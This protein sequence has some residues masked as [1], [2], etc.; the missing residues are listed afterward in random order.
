MDDNWHLK[1][2]EETFITLKSG[3]KGLTHIDAKKRLREFGPNRLETSKGPSAWVIFFRQF[4]NPLILILIVASAVKLFVSGFLDG[5][6]LITTIL[7][8]AFI[9]FFQE[10]KAEKA[11]R[12]LKK[13]AAHKSKVIRNS[14]VE[15]VLTENL[16]PGDLILLEMGDK[17]PADA[18]LIEVK[19]LKIDESMLDGESIPSEKHSR[20]LEGTPVVAD[21]ENMVYAGTVVSYGKAS[22]VVVA[23]GMKTEL[24][25]IAASIDEIHPE[26]TPVQRSIQSIGNWMLVIVFIAIALFA[27]ISFYKGMP[28]IDIFLLGVAAAVS[29]I[30]E[31]LPIAFTTTLAAGMN[32]MA[33]RNAI[34]RKLIAVETLGSTTAICSDKTGTLTL[35]QMTVTTLYTFERTVEV[36]QHCECLPLFKQMFEIGALCNDAHL[37]KEGGEFKTIGDPT[38]GALLSVAAKAGF[39]FNSPRLNEIPFLSETRYMATLHETELGKRI[40]VKGAPEKVLSLCGLIQTQNGT[41]PLEGAAKEQIQQAIDQMTEKALRLIAVAYLDSSDLI[42]EAFTGKLIFAGIFG[43]IDPPRKEAMEAIHSCRQAGIRVSMITGDNK[44]TALAIAKE[45]GISTRHALTGEELSALSD[46]ELKERSKTT[47]V[48][49]R[50]EPAHKLRIVRAFQSNGQIVAVTGDGIN[51]APALEA[52]N[53][54]IAMG[55]TGTDVAKESADMILADDRFDSIVAAVEEGRAIFNRL[56]NVCAFLL[57]TCIGELFGLILAVFFIG[58]APLL[59][60]QILWVNLVSGSVIAIPLGFEPKIG[61]EMKHPPRDPHSMLLYPG[62][63]YRIGFLAILLGAGT[64]SIFYYTYHHTSLEKAR[65][66]V[67]CALVAFEWLIALK[68]RSEELPI[69]KIGI[70]KNPSLLLAI[71]VALLL[72]LLILYIPALQVLFHTQP[73]SLSEWGIALLPGISI[74]ILETLRKEFLPNLFSAGKWRSVK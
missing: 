24:G 57:T 55:L 3:L 5:A 68:M 54:G 63:L 66:M 45:L 37:S 21:R 15:M 61:D 2:V 67:L 72:H 70:F 19:T 43:M 33:K 32:E 30:P 74:F 6:V 48:Y 50:V 39:Q 9:G 17:V 42:E 25:K 35:N 1:T 69:R 29:A 4:M 47:S 7:L 40:Y 58:L 53:I 59:P 46:P 26:P 12:A 44:K 27:L 41:I 56:R 34:I 51:D 62:M 11:M 28:W 71:G 60:L 20:A 52:S 23:T 18:R 22:A 16:V 8:M 13:L 73:L 38:E 14:K 64:F 49:A 10:R 65:T 31:G 36:G